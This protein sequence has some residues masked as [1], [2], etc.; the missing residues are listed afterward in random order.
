MISRVLKTEG[1]AEDYATSPVNG[2]ASY[3]SPFPRS[4]HSKRQYRQPS[5][6]CRQPIHIRQ[7]GSHPRAQMP[8]PD[9]KLESEEVFVPVGGQI[10]NWMDR[11]SNKQEEGKRHPQLMLGFCKVFWHML[12]A[13]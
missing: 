5:N 1:Q 4:V 3:P 11:I 12:Q 8:V 9:T 6:Q 7:Q 10:R 13:I 2:S